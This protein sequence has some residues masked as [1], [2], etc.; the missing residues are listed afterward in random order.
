VE[1][2]DVLNILDGDIN[3]YIKAFLMQN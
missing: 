3:D 1:R 2:S